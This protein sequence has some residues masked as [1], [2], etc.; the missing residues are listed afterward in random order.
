MSGPLSEGLGQLEACLPQTSCGL[1]SIKSVIAFV[2]QLSKCF[3]HRVQPVILFFYFYPG[4]HSTN[5]T[6]PELWTTLGTESTDTW[7]REQYFR[8]I[9]RSQRSILEAQVGL[10]LSKKLHNN[11]LKCLLIFSVA[12]FKRYYP[13]TQMAP[14]T[15]ATFGLYKLQ[16]C[17]FLLKRYALKAGNLIFTLN[18]AHVH[19]NI[20]IFEP[21]LYC[22][23]GSV[24]PLK[25]D[26][27]HK[28]IH[29]LYECVHNCRIRPL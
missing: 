10:R 20:H 16:H 9:T 13:L 21:E 23:R 25:V 26:T 14:L 11:S 17:T 4:L 29:I 22:G 15:Q 3:S 12:C 18:M 6:G 5:T 8:S 27:V 7:S 2:C 28:Y 19:A 24:N 1:F